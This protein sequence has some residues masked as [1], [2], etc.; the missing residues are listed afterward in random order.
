MLKFLITGEQ[1]PG[2][3][4]V[5]ALVYSGTSMPFVLSSVLELLQTQ[6]P[7]AASPWKMPN[8]PQCGL[9]ET[10]ILSWAQIR[11]TWPGREVA[12][13]LSAT[14]YSCL[15]SCCPSSKW[16]QSHSGHLKPLKHAWKEGLSVPSIP[17]TVTRFTLQDSITSFPYWALRYSNIHLGQHKNLKHIV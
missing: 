6:G 5:L 11:K 10:W 17:S 16:R 12:S 9:L 15:C 4:Q 7:K 8:V 3:S 1:V 2:I 14:G 13:A